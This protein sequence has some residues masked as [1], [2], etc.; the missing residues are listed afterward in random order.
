MFSE[1]SN[2]ADISW[3]F[4]FSVE[5]LKIKEISLKFEKKTYENGDIKLMV[6][7]DIG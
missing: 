4:D 3:N 1:D 5:N 2:E 6:L 7:N